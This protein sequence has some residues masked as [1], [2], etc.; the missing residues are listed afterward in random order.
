[1]LS[2]LMNTMVVDIM[3]QSES[4]K[5]SLFHSEKALFGYCAFHHMLLGFADRYPVIVDT[6]NAKVQAFLKD[7][8]QRIK[9]AVPNLGEF[10]IYLTLSDL[11]WDDLVVAIV[12]ELFDRNVKWILDKAPELA[13][14]SGVCYRRRRSF[15][16][17][18]TGARLL[19][20][21]KFFLH[22]VRPKQPRQPGQGPAPNNWRETLKAANRSLGRPAPG[23]AEKLQQ[24]CKQIHRIDD[25]D[26]FCAYLRLQ[27]QTPQQLNA[28][29]LHAVSNSAAKGYHRPPGSN[30]VNDTHQG[31][32]GD[33]GSRGG[34]RG[35]GGRG[36]YGNSHHHSSSHRQSHAHANHMHRPQVDAQRCLCGGEVC[37]FQ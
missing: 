24:A 15:Q 7:P 16:H 28:R 37:G 6:A 10:L 26:D 35:R 31:Q 29:L 34:Y 18:R 8:S 13:Y 2:T 4:G 32:R 12:L 11:E 20:F 19:M 27:A 30:R 14:Q 21:Q 33:Y 25:Y 9:K 1:M 22:Q 3:N 17:S 36:G 23:L 5:A